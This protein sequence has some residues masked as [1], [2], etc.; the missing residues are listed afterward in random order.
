LIVNSAGGGRPVATS[1]RIDVP[2]SITQNDHNARAVV[3]ATAANGS[4]PA[5]QVTMSY[6]GFQGG[7]AFAHELVNGSTA[8]T[9]HRLPVRTYTHTATYAAYCTYQPSAV[10]IW[11]IVNSAGGGRPVATSIRIDVPASITQ[12]D[13]NARAVVAVTAAD[14]SIPTGQVSMS[15]SGFQ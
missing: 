6:S 5:G 14:G 13:H 8:Y 9:V 7:T 3:T 15:F 12:N 11:L 10:P 4:I 1:I 2:A